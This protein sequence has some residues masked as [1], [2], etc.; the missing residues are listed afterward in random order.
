MRNASA[1]FN[2]SMSLM[3]TIAIM[4]IMGVILV[5]LDYLMASETDTLMLLR[6]LGIELGV[7]MIILVQFGSKVMYLYSTELSSTF[8][9]STAGGSTAGSSGG[10]RTQKCKAAKMAASRGRFRLT[11]KILEA[12]E[13]AMATISEPQFFFE[14]T[15]GKSY[16]CM[17]PH[18]SSRNNASSRRMNNNNSGNVS[19]RSVSVKT[20]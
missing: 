16:S 6:S 7:F 2:E 14:E 20:P 11:P 17:S 3:A 4:I 9:S 13:M 1:E 19:S 12:G 10:S 8:G 5:P 18:N 15:F